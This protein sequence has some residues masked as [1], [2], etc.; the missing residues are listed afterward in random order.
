MSARELGDFIIAEC[1][2]ICVKLASLKPYV[3]VAFERI[4]A[5]ESICGY[6]S[7]TAF[8]ENV[9]GRTYNA[10]K[11]MLQGGNPRNVEWKTPEPNPLAELQPEVISALVSPGGEQNE[12][13]SLVESAKRDDFGSLAKSMLAQRSGLT[14]VPD[15]APAP[16]PVPVPTTTTAPTPDRKPEI[17]IN[18]V[19]SELIRDLESASRLAR[20]KAVVESRQR[21]NPTLRLKLISALSHAAQ[22]NATFETQL[23][24]DFGPFPNNGKC[25]QRIVREQNALQPEPDERLKREAAESLANTSVR[26]ISYPEA[27][28]IILANEYLASMGTTRYTFGLFFKHPKTGVEY[29]GGVECYGSTAGSNVFASVC[30]PEHKDKVITVVCG[31]CLPWT[32]HEVVS[33]GKVH[34]GAAASYLLA[35]AC[36]L[37]TQKGYNI[38]VG[39]CDPEA[40]E[41]GTI[42]QA[43]NWEY[44]GMTNPTERFSKSRFL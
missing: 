26:E 36:D 7:K 4:D 35:R 18:V 10:A 17:N 39:Y 43:S 38:F 19:A 24:S 9:L 2:G 14:V 8:S 42:Y 3:R 29:L 11:F 30:G 23:P 22:N 15:S 1:N 12:A 16:E 34:R 28:N 20:L 40:G 32:D 6:T 44:C 5:G 37:M 21:L 33:K 41:I 27:K 31:A 13:D 25:H